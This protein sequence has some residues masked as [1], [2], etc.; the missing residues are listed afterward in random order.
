M[1]RAGEWG[2]A[3]WPFF[4]PFALFYTMVCEMRDETNNTLKT[5]K[6]APDKERINADIDVVHVFL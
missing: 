1:S 5:T 2:P 6:T 4:R 3:L